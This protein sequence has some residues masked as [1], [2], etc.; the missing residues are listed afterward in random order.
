MELSRHVIHPKPIVSSAISSHPQIPRLDSRRGLIL[1]QRSES[2]IRLH[3]AELREQSLRLI[4]LDAGVDN[5]I[6]T[7]DPVDRGSDTVLVTSLKRV[8]YP[9]NLGGVTAGGSG[10]RED[11]A[12]GLLGVDDEN[13]TDGECNALGVDIGGV[14]VVKHIISISNLS[15]LVTDNGEG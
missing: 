12:N 6:I 2:K 11:K 13:G 9:E 3:N 10:V 14:L 8:D 4:V 7:W 1:W 5:N 15:L